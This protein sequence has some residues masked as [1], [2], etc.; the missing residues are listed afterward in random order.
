M[1]W[2]PNQSDIHDQQNQNDTEKITEKNC[3]GL[4]LIIYFSNYIT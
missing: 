2:E 4:F 1:C 3:E